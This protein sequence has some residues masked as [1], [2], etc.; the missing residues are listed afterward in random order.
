MEV[1]LDSFLS[2]HGIASR[3]KSKELILDGV[4]IVNDKTVYE[5]IRINPDKDKVEVFGEVVASKSPVKHY[6]MLNKPLNILSSTTDDRDRDTV[7]DLVKI[8]QSIYPVG[9]LDLNSTGLILLTNDGDFALKITHPRYHVSKKYI[10]K[11][12]ENI[13]DAKLDRLRKG[14]TIYGQKTQPSEI[15]RTSKNGFEITL[16]QGL[17]RQIRMMCREVGCHVIELHRSHIGNLS[18]GDLKTGEYRDLTEKEV[19][20]LLEG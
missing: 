19:K 11:T 9:R 20:D 1:R 15:L 6:I 4:V 8:D 10:V 17:K 12:R 2:K 7:L 13:S 5:V 3:R 14:V 18:L 16:H